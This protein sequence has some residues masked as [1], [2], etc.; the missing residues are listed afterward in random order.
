MKNRKLLTILMSI[1]YF[2]FCIF[3]I[4]HNAGFNI[5]R[6]FNG[7]YL[8]FLSISIVVFLTLMRVIK[9]MDTDESNDL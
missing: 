5:D 3:V 6:L 7:K 9:E 1:F 8:V 2:V 4:F